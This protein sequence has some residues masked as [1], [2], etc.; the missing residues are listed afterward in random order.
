M[1]FFSRKISYRIRNFILIFFLL[2]L[3]FSLSAQATQDLQI[4]FPKTA[5][6][7]DTVEIKYIF[8]SDANIFPDE[9]FKSSAK[10]SMRTDYDIF[11]NHKDDFALK[12]IFLEK[13]GSD[14]T[15]TMKIVPWEP[16]Y[17]LLPA[18]NLSALAQF[19]AKK[20]A[21]ESDFFMNSSNFAPFMVSLKP[22]QI[23]SIAEK[24]KSVDFQAQAAPQLLPGTSLYLAVMILFYLFLIFTVIFLLLKF[25]VAAKGIEKIKYLFSLKK[26]SRK[27]AKKLK[28]LLK[29]SEKIQ[30]DKEFARIFQQILR[31]YL[32]KRFSRDFSSIPTNALYSE[33]L[34]IACGELS[35]IQENAVELL[36]EIFF[37]T[38]YVRYSQN[39][40][41]QSGERESLVSKSLSMLVL[42]DKNPDEKSEAQ[43]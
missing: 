40:K 31:D 35:E 42:F 7:G 37:R 43:K 13:L 22:I 39:P 11:E 16:G 34:E 9:F 41:F 26:N 8:H 28:K 12:E 38:D 33:F 30:D 14:Y 21:D 24:Y 23:N 32:N 6:T 2:F 10:F 3:T 19:S 15:L 27:T 18:F 1:D 25:S 36:T 29:N 17:L 20:N 4:A 5:F